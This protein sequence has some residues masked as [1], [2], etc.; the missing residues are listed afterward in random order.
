[1]KHYRNI[2]LFALF[3]VGST[4]LMMAQSTVNQCK[5]SFAPGM[6][7]SMIQQYN[8]QSMPKSSQQTGTRVIL[9]AA[10]VVR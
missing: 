9:I 5:V 3:F 2:I 4:V 10:H 1:M 7:A 8:S 6:N